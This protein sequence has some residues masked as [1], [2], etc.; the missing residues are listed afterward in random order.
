MA[1]AMTTDNPY[2][3]GYTQVSNGEVINLQRYPLKVLQTVIDQSEIYSL[4]SDD[5][6]TRIA[7]EK[8]GNPRE[9]WVIADY[10]NIKEP[11]DISGFDS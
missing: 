8:Y 6:L 3:V 4:K 10:N 1:T 7:N 5:T 9:W 11:W 2:R